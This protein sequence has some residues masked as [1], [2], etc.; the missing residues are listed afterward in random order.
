MNWAA[1]P[2]FQVRLEDS[3]VNSHS[4]DTSIHQ[5][6]KAL[7]RVIALG[8]CCTVGACASIGLGG[9]DM[10]IDHQSTGSITANPTLLA[11]IDPSDWTI[12]LNTI[13]SL[14][15]KSL[16]SGKPMTSWN[17]PET[18]SK[19][20]ITQVAVRQSLQDEECRSF[21]SSMHRVT[22]VENIAGEICRGTGGNWQI[23]EFATDTTA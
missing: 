6:M 13:S 9:A 12:L 7:G 21:T 14:D 16:A 23:T 4:T 20:Q 8:C 2:I 1:E 17:N 11:G 22:G 5:R 19:G 15:A 10:A 3:Q 18:G